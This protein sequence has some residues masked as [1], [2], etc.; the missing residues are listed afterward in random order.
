MLPPSSSAQFL[1]THQ[2]VEKERDVRRRKDLADRHRSDANPV[3]LKLI[4]GFHRPPALRHHLC[5]RS[6]GRKPPAAV[7]PLE[8]GVL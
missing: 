4:G 2:R 5:S 1:T 8:G 6:A 7:Q 3:Y